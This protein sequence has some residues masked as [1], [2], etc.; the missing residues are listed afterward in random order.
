MRAPTPRLASAAVALTLAAM[1]TGPAPAAAQ[2][3]AAHPSW[4][5]L[6][7]SNGFGAAVYDVDRRRLSSWR[8]HVYAQRD[9]QT[10]TAD[11]MFDLYPGLRVD[12][13]NLWMSERPVSAA[14]YDDGRGLV[15]V[16]HTWGALRLTQWIITP[17]TVAAPALVVVFEVENTGTAPLAD[18]ALFTLHNLRVG[19]DAGTTAERITW[20][21]GAF[22]ER[23]ARGLVL[24]RPVPAPDAHAASPSNPYDR[25]LAGQRLTSVDDSG[26]RDDAVSG[27]EWDLTG[28]GAGARRTV[29]VV[30]GHAADGDRARLE[31]ALPALA[32][33]GAAVLAAE[34]AGWDTFF[35]RAAV[36]PGASADELAVYRQQLAVL[37]M[38]QVV[39]PGPGHGQLVASLPPG[40]WNISWVRDQAYALLGLI[41]AGLADEARAA[42]SFWWQGRAGT[43]V[44]CDRDGGPWVGAD[45]AISVVRYFG[46]GSEESDWNERGPNVEFDGFGLALRATAAYLAATGDLAL[47]EAHADAIFRRTADVLLGLI[48]PSGAAAGLIRADSSIWE[49]HWY[50]GGRRHHVFTQATAVAGLR[51]GADLADALGRTD[52]AARYRAGADRVAE[53]VRTRM[54]DPASGVLRSS[55]EETSAFLDGAAVEAWNWGVI[56]P[57][58]PSLVATLDAFRAGLWNPAVG[59]GYRRND[60]GGEYDLREWAVIDLRLAS[61]ARLAGRADHAEALIGWV[62]AQAR[63]NYDLIAE[64]F[65]RTT[66]DFQG[67]V[68]MVGFGAGAYVMALWDRAAA[69]Q[70]P[71][72]GADAG[73][74]Q[75]PADPAGCGCQG[76]RRGSGAMAVALL[77]GLVLRAR[78]RRR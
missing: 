23:G 76:G 26:V 65:D 32:A 59:Q 75:P 29:A 72:G 31:A 46:D 62:T 43:F 57:D 44:C 12:G 68:P 77:V 51:A 69:L 16:V 58:H 60:D 27:F 17:W 71:G 2:A 78:T 73:M 63:A 56:E 45:Y 28:L 54:I 41:A 11:L 22:E 52:D 67:E 25:V 1:T 42:L 19:G 48:E 61:A 33:D 8:A 38:A 53:A 35:A 34:R 37:R 49:T 30:L 24:A 70:P 50:D 5:S 74:G 9:A 18:A 36:P 64:N 13:A 20:S 39:E 47:V 10:T 15:R 7:L 21:G 55:T 6:S 66:G 40:K 14:G 3:I 4:S